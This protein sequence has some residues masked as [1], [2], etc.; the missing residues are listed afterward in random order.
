MTSLNG[1]PRCGACGGSLGDPLHV[2]DHTYV[3]CVACGS[4]ELSPMPALDPA[5]YYDADYF[6]ANRV[7]GYVDY[8]ADRDEH[9]RNAVARVSLVDRHVQRRSPGAGTHLIDVGCASGYVLDEARERGWTVTG[10][11][12]SPW[13]QQQV[14]EKGHAVHPLLGTAAAERR[15][16]A[17]TFF[18]SLEHLLDPW[19]HLAI[20]ADVLDPGGVVVIETWDSASRVARIAGTRWQ[21]LSPPSVTHLF[22]T[23]G[24]RRR[25]ARSGLAVVAA[26]PTSKRV[27]GRLVAGVV[28]Q[29][30]PRHRERIDRLGRSPLGRVAVPYRLGDLVT[31]VA[32]RI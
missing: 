16:D 13:A 20:A 30:L 7:G 24:L 26:G 31:V 2:R 4:A 9:V 27:T 29:H 17:I 32:R 15:P 19:D 14:V 28:A 1:T 21:Q 8:D 18:Q 25:L 23:D 5:A 12:V 22:T 10:V 3:R 11:D 6:T